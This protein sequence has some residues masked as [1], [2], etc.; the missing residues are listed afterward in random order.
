VENLEPKT[1]LEHYLAKIA[2]EDVITPEVKTRLEYYLNEI[3]ENGGGGN[4]GYSKEEVRVN[5][6]PEDEYT[7]HEVA[8]IGMAVTDN[9]ELIN[10]PDDPSTIETIIMTF[11]NEEYEVSI[12]PGYED[13][14]Y[15]SDN[16]TFFDDRPPMVDFTKYPFGLIIG[17]HPY[18]DEVN[19]VTPEPCT[20]T[21]KGD[22][23]TDEIITTPEFEEAVKLVSS[24]PI[25][26]CHIEESG[27]TV[28]NITTRDLVN[29]LQHGNFPIL[30]KNQDGE[31]KLCSFISYAY[32]P[33]ESLYTFKFDALY[34]SN[35][36]A[37][38]PA[39]SD[40]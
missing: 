37:D 9:I 3:A 7:T 31:Y 33:G 2:G 29:L 35:N 30:Q 14:I 22:V 20:F 13:S 17:S 5:L 4:P 16:I 1:R 24:N 6:I 39:G 11:N 15:S 36:L 19:I 34:Y 26:T 25:I 21:T 12:I 40:K 27:G 28:L 18:G 10:V 38:Y 23:V 32:S 8:E